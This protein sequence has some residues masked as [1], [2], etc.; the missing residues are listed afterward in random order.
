MYNTNAK[1]VNKSRRGT[2]LLA[3]NDLRTRICR[4]YTPPTSIVMKMRQ[5]APSSSSS[6]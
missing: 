6:Q 2:L 1:K 4:Q 3:K 5:Q